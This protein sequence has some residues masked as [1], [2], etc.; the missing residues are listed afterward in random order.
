VSILPVD[1]PTGTLKSSTASRNRLN[2]G[3]IRSRTITLGIGLLLVAGACSDGDGGDVTTASGEPVALVGPTATA[4]PTDNVG[5]TN[6]TT[7]PSTTTM[8]PATTTIT[9]TA[10][11]PPPD[12]ERVDCLTLANGA[13]FISQSGLAAGSASEVLEVI[14]GGPD[15][16]TVSIDAQPPFEFVY[17]LPIETTFDRFAVPN[18]EESPGNAAL[19]RDLEIAGSSEGPEAG[20]QVPVSAALE[21]HGPEETVGLGETAPLL[22]PDR[23][24][25]ARSINRRVEIEC[26]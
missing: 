26:G 24:E 19:Y 22:S 5:T 8:A 20:Y 11:V 3:L 17:G 7:A 10:P 9:T 12:I 21:T 4:Q 23:D 13:L 2:G 15:T 6:T 1:A 25:S 18:I 14:D 16:R